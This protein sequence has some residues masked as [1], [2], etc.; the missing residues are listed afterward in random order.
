MPMA[1]KSSRAR[2]QIHTTAVIQATVLNPLGHWGTPPYSCLDQQDAA[3]DTW[4]FQAQVIKG[5]I[6]CLHLLL[7][8]KILPLGFSHFLMRKPGPHMGLLPTFPVR[9]TVNSQHQ[10]LDM[11]MKSLKVIQSS[12]SIRCGTEEAILV[13]Y[14]NS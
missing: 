2:D 6:L 10:P 11:G 13:P 4:N 1:C 8:L 12:N 5:N 14:L 9:L 3:E 7:F